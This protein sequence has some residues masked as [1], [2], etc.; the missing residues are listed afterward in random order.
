MPPASLLRRGD[1]VSGL[2]LAALGAFIVV[3]ALAWD[4]M[5]PDGPGAG[6]FPRWYG[7]AMIVLSLVLVVRSVR[8]PAPVATKTVDASY[9]R[10]LACWVALVACILLSKPLG[11]IASFALLCWFVSTTLFA[12]KQRSAIPLALGTALAFWLVFNRA[13]DVALPPGPWGL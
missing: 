5:T 7:L 1:F 12:L 2:V 13:L 3:Q 8:S 10:A 4:Y 6:F 9:G 11:F